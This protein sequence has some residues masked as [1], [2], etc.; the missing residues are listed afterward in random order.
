MIFSVTERQVVTKTGWACDQ[1][2]FNNGHQSFFNQNPFHGDRGPGERFVNTSVVPFSLRRELAGCLGTTALVP[3][4]AAAL[5]L[6]LVSRG[7]IHSAHAW[8]WLPFLFVLPPSS[9]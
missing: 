9:S 4:S 8:G 5:N 2:A 1:L 7:A 6:K 3:A